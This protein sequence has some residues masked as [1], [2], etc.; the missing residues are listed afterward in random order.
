M[1][2]LLDQSEA[3]VQVRWRS[4][5][6]HRPASDFLTWDWDPPQPTVKIIQ[7]DEKQKIWIK[8]LKIMDK[9]SQH[10]IRLSDSTFNVRKKLLTPGTIVRDCCNC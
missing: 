7:L 4:S 1:P 3:R 10:L 9:P 5:A 8:F 6:N 2:R